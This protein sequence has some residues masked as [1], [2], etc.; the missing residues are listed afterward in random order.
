MQDTVKVLKYPLEA[1][2]SVRSATGTGTL[3]T[4]RASFWRRYCPFDEVVEDLENCY[5]LEVSGTDGDETE[6][7]RRLHVKIK[8]ALHGNSDLPAL[9]AVVG[10]RVRMI[11]IATAEE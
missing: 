10:F 9:A 3:Y 2:C 6:V 7:N 11:V 8:Q 4:T 5:R 1:P